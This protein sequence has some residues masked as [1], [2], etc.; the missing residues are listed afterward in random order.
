MKRR[1]KKLAA[2]GL[3]AVMTTGLLAGCGNGQAGSEK[4]DSKEAD[5][6]AKKETTLEVE[7][8]YTGQ[9]LDQFREVLDGF[10][11]ET[12]IGIELVHRV[13]IMRLL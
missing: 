9:P 3:A 10:T 8:I 5:K 7:V 11:E 2:F 12:G 1:L 13:Q 6:S 4:T